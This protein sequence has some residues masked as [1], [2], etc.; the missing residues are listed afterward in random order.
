MSASIGLPYSGR[1]ASLAAQTEAPPPGPKWAKD[2][3]DGGEGSIS[4]GPKVLDDGLVMVEH[5]TDRRAMAKSI[6]LL[7]T[8]SSHLQ[9]PRYGV[10]GLPFCTFDISLI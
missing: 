7:N 4:W 10:S 9:Y 1:G 5:P 6:A 2:W 3:R 8:C